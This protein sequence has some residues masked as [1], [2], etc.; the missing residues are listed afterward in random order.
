[1]P[2]RRRWAS[3]SPTFPTRTPTGTRRTPATHAQ[4]FI[5]I[6]AGLGI[7]PD[8]YYW[9]SDIY[10][11]GERWTRTSA[12]ARQGRARPRHLPPRRQR[13]APGRLAPAPGRLRELRQGRD[14]DRHRLGRRAGHVRVPANGSS[15]WAHGC[16][17][18]GRVAPFGGQRQAAVEPRVGRPVVA[19][20]RDDRAV[21][22]GPRDRRRVARPLRRDRPRGVR[23]RA[24]A[25]RPVRVHQHRRQEDVDLQGSRRGRPRDR[26]GDAARSSSA[27]SSSARSR[28]PP[29]SS[30]RRAPTRS[31]GC[32]TS[33]TGSPPRPP[34]AR[35][36]ASS[37]RATRRRSAT[38]CSTRTPTSRR[39]PPLFR[40]AF[41]HLALLV[42]I[43]NVDVAARV[44][45]EKG[46]PL[47]E[48]ERA[49]P[50]RSGS[51]PR[52]AGSRSTRPS[53]RGSRSG[54]TRCPRRPPPW[55]TPS[56]ATSPRS[57]MPSSAAGRRRATRGRT[58]SS[59]PPRNSGSS[60]GP[61]SRRCTSRSSAGPTV[62]GPAGC[63]PASIAT[64]WSSGCARPPPDGASDG[65]RGMSVGLQRLREDA[66]RDP[67]GR[68]RQGRGPGARRPGTR[69]GHAPAG[70][71]RR[72]RSAQG[73]AE[74]GLE[75]D[76]RGDQGR[77]VARTARRSRS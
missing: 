67:Q 1:M 23:A 41:A 76:R 3:R 56:A 51:G 62:R 24:A 69:A 47:N 68:G 4:V 20:R 66:G 61:R 21:R 63:W 34:G 22:Q 15:T 17:H 19:V 35:S 37:P 46:S 31:R 75:A 48:R 5:D 45:A 74:R 26:R 39:R 27:S 44:E 73:R 18:R 2:S 36:R 42:Q 49:D 13:P 70:A 33:S 28:T 54:A 11:T 65:G 43:P 16:G 10:P 12:R 25:Q 57:P 30:T 58:R 9:M 72:G 8:R 53:E 50:R 14:D 52:G 6:F 77:R 38:R 40:P 60:R 29:S 71:P 59:P 32:S 55:M 64:S 7:R